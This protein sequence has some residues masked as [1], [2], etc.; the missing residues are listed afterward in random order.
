MQLRYRKTPGLRL[1]RTMIG[2]GAGIE[3]RFAVANVRWD[4]SW[5]PKAAGASVQFYWAT[6]LASFYM[7][8]RTPFLTLIWSVAM[9]Y[10]KG[11]MA[12]VVG[13]IETPG[14]GLDLPLDVRGTAFSSV[15]G[16]RYATFRQGKLRVYGYCMAHR[17]PKIGSGVARACAENK[18]AVVIPC[19]RVVRS[20]GALSGYRWGVER[21]RAL[22]EKE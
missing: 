3:I 21:K 7:I 18:L 8:C 11:F 2:G 16:R 5:L 17:C 14:I 1:P 13:L 20:D 4:R 19:Y 12:E 15:C 22:L 10:S 6:I 9:R